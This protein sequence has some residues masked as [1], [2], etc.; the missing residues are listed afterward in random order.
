[1]VG[2]FPSRIDFASASPRDVGVLSFK[3]NGITMTRYFLV[4]ASVG[5]TA[6]A[7]YFFNV[8]D[9]LLHALKRT[10]TGS[11]I[12]YASVRTILSFRNLVVT[13][14]RDRRTKEE[15]NLTNL[16]ILKSPHVSGSLTYPVHPEY[17]GGLFNC[18]LARKMGVSD[19]LRLLASLMHG[20]IP[21]SSKLE[22]WTCSG[23]A[24]FS[25][26]PFAVEFDGEIATTAEVRF[27]VLPHHLQVCQ[28]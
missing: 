5:L 23:L 11:A 4:N 7:N 9:L 10:S 16:N 13:L 12:A 15:V 27:S 8:P 21:S 18:F 14:Q 22:H 17:D 20:R 25:S 19:R 3:E 2:E 1:M 26:I 28:C 24:I 6:T